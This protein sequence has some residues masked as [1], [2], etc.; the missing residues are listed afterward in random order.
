METS[1]Q[2]GRHGRRV[3]PVLLSY[4]FSILASVGW[5]LVHFPRCCRHRKRKVSR[6]P[7]Y[8]PVQKPASSVNCEDWDPENWECEETSWQRCRYSSIGVSYDEA[9]IMASDP[10]EGFHE[11]NLASPT[12]PD[13][14]GV[15]E[16]G[17]QEQTT[18][19]SVIYRPHPS[20]VSS[21]PIQPNAL[22]VSDLPTQPVY[23][24][25]RQLNCGEASGVSINVTDAVL[26]STSGP[27]GGS[28]NHRK[29]SNNVEREFLQGATVADVAEGN[30]DIFGLSTDSLS[31][32][33]SPSVLEVREK[34][35]ERLKEELAKAQREAHK[36][37]KEANVKQAAAEK[38]LKEAQGKIDV[39]QAEVAALKTLVLSTSPTSPT[40]EFQS[41][42]KTPFKKGHTRNKST[43]SA[44]GGSHQDL[45]MMQPIVKD[46]KE[47]D[48]SLYNEFRSWKDE[49]TMD[50]TCPFLD[51]IYREDI[52]PC[53]TFSKSELASAVLEAVENN[54]L[55]IEPVGLQPVRFVKAS[56]VEC[57]GP[58][59]CALSGQS[60]S[61]KH[62]I[63]LGDSSSYY[64]ISPFCRYRI[65]S[66]CN[67]FTYIRYIQQGLLKQQDVDQMFWEVMQLRR[68]MSLAKLG[69]YK[70]EL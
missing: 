42:G 17:T 48:L 1:Q 20:V 43:S 52:F 4:V 19:P 30:E 55:S 18:S 65:T 57:G 7:F 13:L 2:K 49:P 47:A 14:L 23:S 24:S 58:K 70:E 8:I 41:S 27:Q 50:R 36:M 68:E 28:F 51:K 66:V 11:V 38:Q 53:L 62:R 15:N 25:P 59:K 34:G 39:L 29:E 5:V 31:H 46:C 26:C 32:L 35:Y 61:C 69:Y 9:F 64:Y 37:V 16:P 56:A 22:N 33:R 21:T 40:K 10:L 45:T 54:T 63:K 67:F 3:V 12:T 60:K 44:M 6:Q